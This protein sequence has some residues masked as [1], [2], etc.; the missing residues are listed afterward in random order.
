MIISYF[1]LDN[2][3]FFYSIFYNISVNL[4][5]SIIE[6]NYNFL[7]YSFFKKDFEWKSGIKVS[8]IFSYIKNKMFSSKKSKEKEKEKDKIK[9]KEKDFKDKEKDKKIVN[10]YIFSFIFVVGFISCS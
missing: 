3:W 10:G 7:L 6:E 2:L 9:E 8:C 5:E 4:I 1:G